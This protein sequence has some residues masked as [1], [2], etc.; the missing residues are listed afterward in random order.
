MHENGRGLAAVT[1]AALAVNFV[2]IKNR[3]H[4]HFSLFEFFVQ[5]SLG[6]DS[7]GGLQHRGAFVLHEDHDEF[8][9]FGLAGISP[10][11]VDILGTFIEGLTRR[12]SHFFPAPHLHYN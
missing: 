10:D 3:V 6:F 1:I 8:R 12:Q 4:L 9:W 2:G 11:D 7:F 5:N